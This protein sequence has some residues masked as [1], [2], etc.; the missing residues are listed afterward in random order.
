MMVEVEGAASQARIE[1]CIWPTA[2]GVISD[3]PSLLSF[4]KSAVERGS[5]WRFLLDPVSMLTRE[6]LTSAE[7]HV[8]RV[9]QTLSMYKAPWGVVLA[10]VIERDGSLVVT[11]LDAA[12]QLTSAVL[13]SWARWRM[14]APVVLVEGDLQQQ[15]ALLQSL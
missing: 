15:V 3:G 13:A 1:L 9:F 10:S 7:D 8:E 12:G 5:T 11:P 6:M 14:A 4:L 2:H